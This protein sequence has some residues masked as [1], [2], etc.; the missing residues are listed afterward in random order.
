MKNSYNCM[1]LGQLRIDNGSSARTPW[2]PNGCTQTTFPGNHGG[3]RRTSANV[4]EFVEIFSCALLACWR[5]VNFQQRLNASGR[6]GLSTLQKCTSA[7]RQLA[8][9]EA[10]NIFD[11]YL[12]VT[13]TI[14]REFRKKS[15]KGVVE[16]FS[17]SYN[18]KSNAAVCQFLLD[19][20]ERVPGF[21]RQA[22]K[23]RLYSLTMEE[24]SDCMERPFHLWVQRH[25]PDDNHRSHC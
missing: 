1:S 6:S 15:S 24:L 11:E 25:T 10:A 12:H 16:A 21:P 3:S 18:R 13:D 22:G 19:L 5:H 23:H 14:G 4:L 8:Y 7:L 17:D 9:E 20:H 2:L